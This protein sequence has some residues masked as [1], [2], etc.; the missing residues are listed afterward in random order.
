M[1]QPLHPSNAKKE[2][3]LWHALAIDEVLSK[4][5]TSQQGLSGVQA[6]ERLRDYGLNSLPPPPRRSQLIRFLLQFHDVLIYVL[7]GAALITAL[8]A[9]WVDAGVILAVVVINAVIGFDLTPAN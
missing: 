4:L 7:L 5:V 2:L 9:D 8:L 6:G 3:P 1:N